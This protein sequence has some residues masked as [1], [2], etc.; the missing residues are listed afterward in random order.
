M[1]FSST[2]QTPLVVAQDRCPRLVAGEESLT[3]LKLDIS[4]YDKA[5]ETLA[6]VRDSQHLKELSII[7]GFAD[8]EV[9]RLVRET[10]LANCSLHR[11]TLDLRECSDNGATYLAEV[12]CMC[13]GRPPPL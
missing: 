2:G 7:G 9:G 1:S 8:E 3:A 6:A 12:N 10:L 4:N 13:A 5:V 11:L